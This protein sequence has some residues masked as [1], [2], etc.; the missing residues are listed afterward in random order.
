MQA[1]FEELLSR[2]TAAVQ[3]GD[4]K[5]L[6]ATFTPDGAYHDVFYGLFE[7]REAIAGMLEGLFH[8]DGTNF[9]WVM[10]E[11]IASGDIGYSRW[12]FSYDSQLPHMAGQRVFMDGVGLFRMR[13]GLFTRYE[14]FARTAEVLAQLGMPTE[15]RDRVAQK[16]LREQMSDAGWAAHGW[17]GKTG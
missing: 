3:A 10:I 2:F 4:G 5:A 13:D 16:M 15:K 14:D 9:K 11:P 1:R 8:R 6:A 12:Q 17:T 7:G